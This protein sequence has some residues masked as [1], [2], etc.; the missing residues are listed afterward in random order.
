GGAR[1]RGRRRIAHRGDGEIRR[2]QAH[3]D[4]PDG[5]AAVVGLVALVDGAEV[6]GAGEQGVPSGGRAG[7]DRDGDRVGGEGAGAE[8]GNGAGATEQHVIRVAHGIERE[9][10]TRGGGAG[11]GGA[12]YQRGDGAGARQQDVAGVAQRVGREV[13][14]GRGRWSAPGRADVLRGVGDGKAGAGGHRGRRGAQRSDDQVG[15]RRPHDDRAAGGP[16]VVGLVG[17]DDL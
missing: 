11:G 8:R 13:V 10:V 6:V 4:R 3:L 2:G 17:L 12:G 1:G 14:A 9:V 16:A 7:G 5:R 15:R